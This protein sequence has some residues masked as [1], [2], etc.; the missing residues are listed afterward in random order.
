MDLNPPKPSHV[1]KNK[2]TF[3]CNFERPEDGR[4]KVEIYSLIWI[5]NY[6][7]AFRSRIDG[8]IDKFFKANYC[9]IGEN[10]KN[11]SVSFQ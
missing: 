10:I 9:Y 4:L 7:L 8:N 1:T 11:V 2:F 3:L 6:H 5:H